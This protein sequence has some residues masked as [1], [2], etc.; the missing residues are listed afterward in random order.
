MKVVLF[1]PD[2]PENT[3]NIGRTCVVTGSGLV[4][5][6]PLG[7]SIA[8]RHLKRAGLD[9]WKDLGVEVIDDLESYIEQSGVSFTFFSSH[10][11]KKYTDI[12]Y[13]QDHLLIFGSETK[14][15]TENFRR[16]WPEHFV[17]IPMKEGERCLNLASSVAIGLYE[18]LRQQSFNSCI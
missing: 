7:F 3:G 8:D 16:R 17:R 6:R 11:T 10:A 9:Y 18:G 15:L 4:L 5:V 1:Q 14:G 13:A 12:T 2:I